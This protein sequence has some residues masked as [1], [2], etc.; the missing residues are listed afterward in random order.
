MLNDIRLHLDS[1]EDIQSQNER[2]FAQQISVSEQAN[3]AAFKRF[4]PSVA[5]TIHNLPSQAISLFIDKHKQ[6]NMVN[7][8]SGASFYPIGVDQ[9]I[10][11]QVDAWQLS[12][13]LLCLQQNDQH[14]PSPLLSNAF[15]AIKQYAED[16]HDCVSQSAIDT[17]VILGLGKGS[18]IPLLLNKLKPKRLVIYEPNLEIFR[19]SLSLF[20]WAGFLEDANKAQLQL[21]LQLGPQAGSVFDDVKELS[22]HTDAKRVL[23]YQHEKNHRSNS[24]IRKVRAGQWSPAVA[25]ID[26]SA[27]HYNDQQLNFLTSI[28]LE[29]WHVVSSKDKLFQGNLALFKQYFPDLYQVFKDYTPSYWEVIKHADLGGINLY[30]RFHSSF[31]SNNDPQNE[32][33]LMANNFSEHPNIDGLA[34]GYSGNKLKHYVHN[35]FI[36]KAN[37]ELNKVTKQ[38]G[39]LPNTVKALLI[40]GVGQAYTL[41]SLYEQKDIQHLIICEPN[42]DFFY[43]ALYAI[44]WAPIFEKIESEGHKLYINIGEASSVLFKDL[45]SQFLALGPH[46]LNETYLLQCYNNPMLQQ[47]LHEVRTQ[48]QVIF[49]M[50]ENFDHVLYG[51]SHTAQAL[52]NNVAALRHNPAQYLSKNDKQLPVFIV[53][54]GPSL[55]DCIEE[56]K[57]CKDEAI[58]VS[59]GTAL[60]ALHR[61]GIVPDFHGEVEQNRANFDWVSRIND[62]EYLKQITLIS[63]NGMHPDTI[64]LFNNVLLSFKQGESSSSAMMA[65][66]PKNSFHTLAFAYPTVSNMAVSFFLSLGF[67]QLYFVGI[68]LGFADQEKHHSQASGYYENGKQ[69]YNYKGRHQA[70]LRAKGNKRAWVFTKTEFNIS[71]MIMEEAISEHKSECFNLSNGVFINK[72]IPLDKENI[73]VLSSAENKRR[74]LG[75]LT[76]CF[77]T[78]SSDVFSMLT[79]SYSYD[80]LIEQV[81]ELILLCQTPFNRKACVDELIQKM[82][83]ATFSSQSKGGSL[84]FYYYFATVNYACAAMSKAILQNDEQAGVLAANNIRQF[85]LESLSDSLSLLAFQ[86]SVVDRSDSFGDRREQLLLQNHEPLFLIFS[87][88]S[89]TNKFAALAKLCQSKI[90]FE[91]GEIRRPAAI[92][93]IMIMHKNDLDFA[94]DLLDKCSEVDTNKLGLI[95]H[96]Y[97]LLNL[98]KQAP[99]FDDV[100]IIYSPNIAVEENLNDAQKQGREPYYLIDEYFHTLWARSQDLSMF[101]EI[102]CKPRFSKTGLINAKAL[103]NNVNQT[104]SDEKSTLFVDNEFE[105]VSLTSIEKNFFPTLQMQTHYM[106]QRYAAVP[107]KHITSINTSDALR[108][109][110]IKVNRNPF[111]F[112]LLG[113]WHIP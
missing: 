94:H 6:S 15:E 71:R 93:L 26:T 62:Y 31:L 92:N 73:L 65:M 78:L 49:S 88:A 24:L 101:K 109:C 70:E 55:D 100:C 103:E 59:C 8:H 4:I 32:G 37:T 63:V 64:A 52:G 39:E 58:V 13:A 2:E 89:T 51:L 14:R 43:A 35:T 77:M 47:V 99:V 74:T 12:S 82:R 98:I 104:P 38:K 67:E 81:Q 27:S 45:M 95:V 105:S 107:R 1:D 60:Q 33:A 16:L 23:F 29:K 41:H 5:Q 30:N 54:N 112:E 42:P 44:D 72:T 75:A 53:G 46:L 66:F 10:Q 56:L 36:N 9:H 57:E 91:V 87:D 48:L 34:F 85:W 11:T 22:Q 61:H 18:H 84:F 28:A 96:S 76:N 90:Q 20:N 106:F 86:F 17:L 25:E 69:I 102:L 79:H 110:G 108:N 80:L 40:F 19:V 97:T 113:V 50:G 83:E 7:I 68:D 21:F 3:I 111:S